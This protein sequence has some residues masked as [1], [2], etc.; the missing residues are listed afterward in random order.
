[1]IP[2]RPMTIEDKMIVEIG[3]G[4]L[5]YLPR[6]TMHTVEGIADSLHA[7]IGFVPLTLREALIA[8]V[9]HLSEFTLPL[10]QTAVPHLGRQIMA[11]DF[12]DLPERIRQ[13]VQ[14]LARN[15]LADEFIA[16]SLQR[17]SSKIVSGLDRLEPAGPGALPISV[18]TRLRHDPLATSHLSGNESKIDF[19][20]PGGHHYIHRGTEQSLG[21]IAATPEFTV[22]DI[23]G[24]IGDEVRI[25][26][27]QKLVDCGFLQIVAS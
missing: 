19:A 26:L 2:N 21:F 18:A 5:L 23:P 1:M 7:S 17:R 9:D 24:D 11:A 25:A 16:N 10:R 4:D 8:C 27:V 20:Y 13:A 22:R 3:P 14:F 12:G 15:C 6:G